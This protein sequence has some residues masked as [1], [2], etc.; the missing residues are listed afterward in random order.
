MSRQAYV[1]RVRLKSIEESLTERQLNLVEDLNRL[2]V[3]S[4]AQLRQLHYSN[5]EAGR[6]AARRDLARLTE[7]RVLA[8]VGRRIGGRGSESYV[9][10]LDLAG[11]RVIDSGRPRYRGPWQPMPTHLQHALEVTDLYVQLRSNSSQA[12]QLARF[13]AEPAAWRRFYGQGGVPATLKPDAFVIVNNG[14]FED[15][16]FLEVDRATEPTT[17]LAGKAKVYVDYWQTGREQ[18][19]HGVFPLVIWV[20]PDERRVQQVGATMTR[21]AKTGLELFSVV[22][23]D[24]VLAKLLADDRSSLRLSDV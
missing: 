4:G 13:D 24:D 3:A 18:A 15:R 20:V 6:R 10:G 16:F 21:V 23:K 11:Q 14:V 5:D 2:R 22:T 19:Q 9:Y 1:T 12:C 17:R 7:L 8:R